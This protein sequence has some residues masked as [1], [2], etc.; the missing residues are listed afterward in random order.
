MSYK[1]PE[2]SSCINLILTNRPHNFENSCIFET[3]LSNL[4]RMT[5]T[6]MKMTFQ[7]FQSRI[8][9]CRDCKKVWQW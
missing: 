4:H 9:N 2:N 5:V 3:C 8:T 6:V 7:R 1:S